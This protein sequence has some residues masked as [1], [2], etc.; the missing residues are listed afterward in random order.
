MSTESVKRD[1]EMRYL[2]TCV[3]LQINMYADSGD[4]DYL[5]KAIAVLRAKIEK[6]GGDEQL[7]G[8]KKR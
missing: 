6:A 1:E 7:C 2:L 4:V 8:L 3:T 5:R